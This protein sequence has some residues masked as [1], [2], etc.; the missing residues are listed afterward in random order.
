[1]EKR[2][3][4]IWKNPIQ[5]GSIQLRNS[6]TTD[7]RDFSLTDG[8]LLVS[9]YDARLQPGSFATIVTV[10]AEQD[11]SFFLRDIRADYPVYIPEYQVAV[12][13]GT[14]PRDYA[15]IVEAVTAKGRKSKI[16]QMESA[17]EETFQAAA[18]HNRDMAVPIWLGLSRDIRMFEGRI[19]TLSDPGDPWD[20]IQPMYHHSPVFLP[21]LEGAPVRYHY[22]A[23][24]GVGCRREI[25]RRLEDGVLPILNVTVKDDEITYHQQMFVCPEI[26][27]LTR[28]AV[29][30]THYLV[31]DLYAKTPTARTPAQQQETDRYHE[32]EI[33]QPEETVLFLQIRAEN[34]SQ[35]PKYAYLRI[36]QPNVPLIAELAECVP[37]LEKGLAFYDSG[38]VFM[39]ATLNAEPAEDVEYAVLLA[40]GEHAVFEFRLPHTP[41][42]RERAEA[43]MSVD[44]NQALT[45]CKAY[46]QQK[47][48]QLAELS[49][50]EKRIQEMMQAGFLHLDL[51]C[52]GNEP[53]GPVAP[54]V[55]VYTPIGTEST[56]II[57]YMESMGATNLA[58]RAVTYFVKKQRPDGFMQNFSTYMS[59]TGLGLWNIAQHYRY[60]KDRSWLRGVA[61]HLVRGCDYIENWTKES[62][63]ESLRK[64]GYGMIFGKVADCAYPF[65]SFMLNATTYGGV[66]NCADVLNE[67]GDPNGARIA[68]FA[69]TYLENIRQT[70]AESF[71]VAPL[72]PLADGSWC[73]AIA[74]WPQIAG[75]MCLFADGG[76]TFS[77]GM[78][79]ECSENGGYDIL[80]GTVAPDSAYGSF[81]VKMITE[82]IALENTAF[83]QPYYSVHP[84][85][86]LLRGEVRS[87]L[88]EF[89]NNVCAL[90]DRETYTFWEHQYQESPHKTHEEAWFLMRCRWMLY[91]EDGQT[92]HFLPGVPRA[93]LEAG[94]TIRFARMRSP[95][96]NLSLHLQ[97]GISENRIDVT[98]QIDPLEGM[99]PEKVTLRIPHPQEKKATCVSEGLY[100]PD[101]ETI[102]LPS[103]QGQK[104]ISV[105]F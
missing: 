88:K 73:P 93:W 92:L 43:L 26:S 90:A 63:D 80:Y 44:Y 100:D 50:P 69:R 22:F 47:L 104:N 91:L 36:P 21:E 5:R 62:M 54:T 3:K 11:F 61:D 45:C 20:T 37:Q 27:P 15:Q 49:L 98:L 74:Q 46:W 9:V 1:M 103:F 99:L 102:T 66:K 35:A 4:I 42:S 33:H 17:P 6:G 57:Q 85:A 52:F 14:D 32:R 77:H 8:T 7:I 82:L 25:H 59:E 58:R 23:G 71:A 72:I 78:M 16:A 60:T 75:P 101:T 18:S 81:I 28:E 29:H 13:E 79:V 64:R 105:Y 89:Y 10:R 94:K 55:G 95:F 34:T 39:T 19:H 51:I 41:I 84:Y 40:P 65:H 24:R 83:S 30:G 2:I 38:R 76:K 31:A 97:S 86:H 56:P 68:A 87:F 96:G 48:D 53:E 67:I 70:L 12:T